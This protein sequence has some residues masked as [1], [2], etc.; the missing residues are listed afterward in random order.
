LFPVVNFLKCI[1]TEVVLFPIFIF[2]TLTFHE[3]VWRH[4][5]RMVGSLITVLLQ[6]F[7]WFRLWNKFEN[8]SIFMKLR[9]MKLRHTKSVPVFLGGHPVQYTVPYYWYWKSVITI[10]CMPEKCT[11][12]QCR[13]AQKSKPLANY[14]KNR[15][16]SYK[17]LSKRLDLC[18]KLK[19][20]SSTIIL[21]VGIRYV[22]LQKSRMLWKVSI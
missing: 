3:V 17:N 20:E 16:K 22:G 12:M 6:M 9:R 14:Q 18:V 7:S 19:Y 1:V 21:F 8:R 11:G 2:N 15:I 13:V 4:T 5:W 10:H